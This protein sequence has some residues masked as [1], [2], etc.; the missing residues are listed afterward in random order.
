MSG[1]FVKEL[2]R[3]NVFRV[4]AIYVI[5]SWLLMQ[6]GDVMFP[7][8]LLPDWTTTMLVAF[9]LLGFPVAMILAWAYE[10]TP[11]GVTRT[12]DVP[13]EQ[14]VTGNTGKKINHLIIAI[15]TVAVIFLVARNWETN[16]DDATNVMAASDKSIAVLP[17]KNTSASAENAE[18]FASGVQDEL[19]T[20]LSKLGNLKVISRTSVE[21]LNPDL[22]VPEIGQLL[23]VATVLE[24]QVQRAGNRLRITVQL[25][26]AADDSHLWANTYDREL[27]AE[28]IFD[29]QSDIARTIVDSLHAELSARDEHSLAN[30]PTRSIEALQ[31]YMLGRQL[32]QRGSWESLSRAER[33]FEEAIALDPDYALAWAQK[34]A[35]RS[36]MLQTGLISVEE[37]VA[38]ADS[39]TR[40]A[41]ELDGDLPEVHAERGRMFWQSGDLAAAE[42]SF[43]RA[44]GLN[45]GNAWS[46]KAYG[47]YLRTTGRPQEA[48][49]ILE[50]ALETDPLSTFILFN[51][52]KAEMYL[53]RPEKNLEYGRRILEIDPSSVSG[54]VS[55]LQSYMSLGR[56]DQMWPW[57]IKAATSSPEDFELWASL[58][59]WSEMLGA[60]QWSTRH[61][62]VASELGPGEPAVLR[63]YVQLFS[64][65]GN[66]LE[67]TNIAHRALEAKLDDRW[68]SDRIFLRQARD[69]AIQRG[70][71]GPALGWYRD[72]HPELFG[73]APEI[74]VDN[75]NAAADLALLLRHAD[76]SGDA[77][78]LIDAALAWH[79]RTQAPGTHGYLIAI[80]DI[81][82]LALNGE[83][84]AAL[85]T[86]REA[87][88]AGWRFD[89]SWYMRNMNLDSIR[90]EPEF[91]TIIKDLQADM[92]AQLKVIR[93]L[94]DMGK[95][96][97][98]YKELSAD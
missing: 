12:A 46:L 70:D 4:A 64:Q 36:R 58:G 92:A 44:L 96:D 75:V 1:S 87:V 82:L 97:L 30:I 13:V 85:D 48:I 69:D 65:Q 37:Y 49:P 32:L 86:L 26:N 89:W 15:L 51:L 91:Q 21:R 62:D 16:N 53:G 28:N 56:F 2:Q 33:Y 17:F 40:R 25:I 55:M 61:M 24:G 72:R 52:G 76:L 79:R 78:L 95:Y 22:S 77:Q 94:P 14:S 5:V 47:N 59:F 93:A 20:L 23:G 80:V 6:I 31:R 18:F 43:N 54:Y 83:K 98:R 67:A 60:T 41:L 10:M 50:R 39:A 68:F 88:D 3:R 35:V 74:T 27:T 29:V 8:L 7:A 19:L 63:S 73:D 66:M 71:L 45:P 42:A 38:V 34:A 90:D 9:L 57:Y 11:D 84:R 81:E